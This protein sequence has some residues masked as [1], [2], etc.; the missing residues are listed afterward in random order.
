M[1][2]NKLRH[3]GRTPICDTIR[4]LY[5]T[6]VIDKRGGHSEM[7]KRVYIQAKKMNRLLC[8][9]RYGKLPPATNDNS[10]NEADWIKELDD[11]KKK[12]DNGL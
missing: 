12:V 9:Y 11:I 5:T 10:W 6:S 4:I 7:L 8:R 2:T 1:N 3:L